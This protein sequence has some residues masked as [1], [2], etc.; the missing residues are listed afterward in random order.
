VVGFDFVEVVPSA[1]VQNLTSLL[2]ARLTLNLMGA[3]VREGQVG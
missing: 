1:D 2:A 3:V